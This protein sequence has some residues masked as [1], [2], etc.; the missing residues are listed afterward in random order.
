MADGALDLAE[1]DPHVVRTSAE[2]TGGEFVRLESTIHP[3]LDADGTA[4]LSHER[5]GVDYTGEHLHRQEERFEVVRGEIRVVFEGT[6]RRLAEGDEITI[7]A[8]TPHRHWNPTDRP[9][10]VAWERRPAGRTEEWAESVYALAQA[11]KTDEEGVPGPVQTAVIVD[12][13]PEEMAY[14]TVLPAGVQRAISS[15]VAPVA[16]LAGYE[17]THSR[18]EVDA[19]E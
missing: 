14:P 19:R 16:R 12:E 18:E 15:V 11:G 3:S 4:D 7:P 5:W 17:A 2:E 8:E 13:F 9:A 6:D 10:R 1:A